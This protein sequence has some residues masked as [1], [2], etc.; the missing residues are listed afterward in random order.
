[1]VK[2][3]YLVVSAAGEAA[4]ATL[5]VYKFRSCSFDPIISRCWFISGLDPA[6]PFVARERSNA[7]PRC[8]RSWGRG[9]SFS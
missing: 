7:F 9:E 4:G 2:K 6:N 3:R 5:S 1:V 8:E